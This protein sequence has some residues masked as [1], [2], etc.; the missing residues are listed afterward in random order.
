VTKRKVDVAA[1]AWR[2]VIDLMQSRKHR[3]LEVAQEWGLTPGHVQ[4]LISLE[5]ENALAMGALAS[6]W[7]CDASHVTFLVDRLEEKGY[8]KRQPAKHDRRVKTI[9]LT[10]AGLTARSA[11]LDRLYEPPEALLELSVAELEALTE[12]LTKVRLAADRG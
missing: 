9:V 3:F 2:S 7:K 10:P 6:S 12:A 8:A 11:I 5:P 4:A 1:D